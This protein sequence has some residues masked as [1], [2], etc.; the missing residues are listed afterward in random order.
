MYRPEDRHGY[1]GGIDHHHGQGCALADGD[2]ALGISLGLDFGGQKA[3]DLV[4]S[5]GGGP[6]I[7]G[8][9]FGRSPVLDFG[10]SGVAFDFNQEFDVL[11]DG[12][13][14][15]FGGRRFVG[16]LRHSAG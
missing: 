15:D 14:L 7:V 16:G 6:G 2:P 8:P 3:P 1:K 9:S 4:C 10:G 11:A 5:G 12:P 13:V